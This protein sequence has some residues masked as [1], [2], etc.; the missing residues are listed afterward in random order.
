[1]VLEAGLVL[2][3][4]RDVRWTSDKTLLW[5]VSVP[6]GLNERRA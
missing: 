1:V 3:R 5:P 2:E 6:V 4:S